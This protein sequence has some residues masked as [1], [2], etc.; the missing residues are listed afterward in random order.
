MKQA[1]TIIL[2]VMVFIVIIA[3]VPLLLRGGVGGVGGLSGGSNPAG[4]FKSFDQGQNWFLR[5]EIMGREG[6]L[7]QFLVNDL[8]INKTKTE[9]MYL[10]TEGAGLY[11]SFDAG[12]TWR[13]VIDEFANLSSQASIFKLVLN[14]DNPDELYIAAFQ[15]DFGFVFGSQDGGRSFEELYL[16]PVEGVA[17]FALAVDSFDFNHILIGTSQGGI[18]E[19]R[20]GGKSWSLIRWFPGAIKRIVVNSADSNEFFVSTISRKLFKTTDGGSSWLDLSNLLGQ[21]SSKAR[22]V[23]D[24]LFDSASSNIIYLATDFGLLESRDGGVSFSV[25][26]LIVPPELLPIFTVAVLPTNPRTIYTAAGNQLFKSEDGG[27]NW[28]VQ[29]LSTQK[30]IKLIT[31][32]PKDFRYIYIG[33]NQ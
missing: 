10:G 27:I 2:V 20:D 30:T 22:Q 32:N 12:E 19:S 16:T 17:V 26:P 9:V 23:E 24:I 21:I 5:E 31:F 8:V 28:S 15:G 18:L 33:L 6:K 3:V 14:A 7:S 11:K 1:L 25:M 4:I 29:A 13:P